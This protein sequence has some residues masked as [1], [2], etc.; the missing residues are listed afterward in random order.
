MHTRRF[1]I[2]STGRRRVV[3]PLILAAV[4][5]ACAVWPAHARAQTRGFQIEEATIAD[6]HRAIQRGQVTCRGIVQ[7][8][9]D[10]AKAYNGACTALVT[11]D[12]APV[13]A[14]TGAVRAGTAVA[15]PT[16]TVPVSS[17]FPSFEEYIGPPFE[18]GR[19]ERTLSDPTVHEQFGM[20]V[21]IPNAGQLNAM[22]TLNVRGE[23]S[24]TCK[25]EFDRHPSAGPLPPGAPAGCEEFRKRPDALE[26]AGELDRQYGTKPD[27]EKMPMYCVVFSWKTWYDAVDMRATGGNDVNF[28]MDVPKADSPDVANLRAKGAISFGVANANSTGGPSLGGAARAST[29]LPNGNYALGAWGGQP[30][31]P[32]DTE[33]VPRGTSSGSGV[34][35]AA[36]LVACSICE[37]TSAS[38]KGPASR[39]N[40]VNLL[41]TKGVMG[42]GGTGYQHAGDR[43]G[44]MCRSVGDAVRVLDASKG[45]ESRDIFTAIPKGIIPRE[46]YAAALVR[47]ADVRNRPLRGMRV[48]IVREFMVKH[49]RNDD[50]ISDQLDKEFKTVLRDRLGADLVE[51]LDPLYPDDPA[52]P[53]VKYTFA[54]AFAEILPHTM[55]EY[56]WQMT[57]SGEPEF[58]VPGWDVRTKDYALALALGRAPLSDK[59][60]LR[61]ISNRLANPRGA[62]YIDKYLQQRGDARVKDWASWVANSKFRSE[63]ERLG[64]EAAVAAN[65]Q[66]P[67]ADAEGINFIKMQTVFRMVVQKVMDENGIDAFVN[68][69]HTVPPYRIGGPD[70]PVVN[71]RPSISC[72]T[73][74]TAL[75]G[76]PEIEVPAGYTTTV[77]EPQWRLSADRTRYENVTGT[78][79]SQLPHPMPISL[80]LWANAGSDAP[81]IKVAS[82][83]E[84]ATHHR[85]PPPAF[86]S[87]VPPGR[88]TR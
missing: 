68:P 31:N 79:A 37:Q 78:V 21:G 19:M 3:T 16:T 9:I 74:F 67:R 73:A 11:R 12:G 63:G 84:A 10:R 29:V 55:P 58:A 44:I 35:V 47:D 7:A 14:V 42:D 53:N 57:T 6:M 20:R 88:G 75:L 77:Y 82:A 5:A 76:G 38:C 25:G 22:A 70:E 46:P 86:G 18:F 83:Y 49:T 34:S 39:N 80:M 40:V 64:A 62:F 87:L 54:D 61:R 48:A 15:F 51:T 60:N 59:L 56:F 71:N 24:V 85:V 50:A 17:M 2:R 69:E 26:R 32:Y 66:D 30:C 27:L 81:V 4:I 65:N 33:R 43:A 8:Y 41:A 28:A 13:P 52:V 36:N 45:F 72:C 23:R 1:K